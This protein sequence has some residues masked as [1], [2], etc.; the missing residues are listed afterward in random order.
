MN[1]QQQ[2]ELWK[3]LVELRRLYPQWRLGQL[4]AN[5]AGWAD[6]DVWEVEDEKLLAAAQQH[7]RQK[8]Q[9]AATA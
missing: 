4:I 5:L 7:L 9:Q 1:E 3:S 2:A 6:Q 8:S